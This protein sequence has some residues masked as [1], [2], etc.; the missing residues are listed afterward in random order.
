MTTATKHKLN[1]T[2]GE[3]TFTLLFDSVAEMNEFKQKNLKNGAKFE[4]NLGTATKRRTSLNP[5]LPIGVT[6]SKGDRK[7]KDG[8]IVISTE[9]KS[10][11]PIGRFA[12][13]INKKCV[14]VA[15]GKKR[16]REMALSNILKKRVE[17]LVQLQ[18]QPQHA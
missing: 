14:A 15:Y 6:E 12:T 7:C 11:E 2:L 16:T 10:G 13:W 8:E 5:E 3:K 4:N 18:Q 1:V 17:F 9:T